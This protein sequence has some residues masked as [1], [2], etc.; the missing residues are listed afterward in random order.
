M[1]GWHDFSCHA[2]A[3]R[4]RPTGTVTFLFTDVEGS[5]RLWETAPEQMASALRRHDEI[6]RGGL[7]DAGGYVFSVAGDSFGA[8]FQDHRQAVTAARRIQAAVA[9]ERWPPAAVISV[10]IGL[11]T[12]VAEERDGN[13]FGT[14]VN[15][16]ARVMS[17]AQ[18]GQVLLSDTMRHL[19]GDGV[20]PLGAVQAKGLADA[21][22]V[23][24]LVLDGEST[25][26]VVRLDSPL[27]RS[28][29]V[30]GQLFGR[31]DDV[32]RTIALLGSRQIVTIVGPGGIG[33]T[34]L[35]RTAA[36]A[37]LGHR[38]GSYLVE[39]APVGTE[40]VV[41]RIASAVG[42][43]ERPGRTMLDSLLTYLAE[44]SVLLVVDNCEHV[45][46]TVAPLV[47]Q[48]TAT[49]PSV[50]VLA[51]S[52]EPLG[53]AD[54]QVIR[55][56]GLASDDAE[57][58][59]VELF[60]ARAARAGAALSNDRP[61]RLAVAAICDRL[62]GLPLAIE[63]AAARTRS[64]TVAEL[65][66]RLERAVQPTGK[67]RSGD[68]RHHAMSATIA[69][70]YDLLDDVER[71]V[72]ERLAVFV[73]GFDLA[74]AEYVCAD[75]SIDADDVFDVVDRLVDKSLVTTHSDG[76]VR[77][78]RLLEPMRWFAWDRLVEADV[79][80]T[81][82][83]RHLEHYA[84]RADSAFR[85]LP[86]RGDTDLLRLLDLDRANLI[87]ATEWAIARGHVDA[88]FRI[89]CAAPIGLMQLR[90]EFHD[91][92]ELLVE[93]PSAGD[94]PRF[95]EALHIPAASAFQR[96][97]AGTLARIR[98][99]SEPLRGRTDAQADL[100]EAIGLLLV[101][102][103]PDRAVEILD[104]LDTESHWVRCMSIFVGATA[105]RELD[106]HDGQRRIRE[107]AEWARSIGARAYEAMILEQLAQGE[108][109]SPQGDPELGARLA[110][111]ALELAEATGLTFV[112]H[113]AR[114]QLARAELR[115][116][117][118]GAATRRTLHTAL[119]ATIDAGVVP[120]QWFVLHTAA[121]LL[122]REGCDVEAALIE[123]CRQHDPFARLRDDTLADVFHVIVP[124]SAQREATVIAP[125]ITSTEHLSRRVLAV[126]EN[127]GLS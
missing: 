110:A 29:D 100:G 59:G 3:V 39:L 47:E 83:D 65:G 97:R 123:A 10:R 93:L 101:D 12:G 40:R 86:A 115:R 24:H 25:V 35:A 109:L 22:R 48:L 70:S 87:T 75:S 118:S 45:I 54:E 82:R 51:T 46:D 78:L 80:G 23:W 117:S 8:A 9:A 90:W 7:L 16:A 32:A 11:H 5:T 14:V 55:L 95:G 21:V 44:R 30:R 20:L 26:P 63:L 71:S 113:Q 77:R 79:L 1:V 120:N 92:A 6:L 19:V 104:R 76:G 105:Y 57:S 52:R 91:L 119:Q 37:V 62:G 112:V 61:T 18:G 103:R 56:D 106:F 68:A 72:F 84:D 85:D 114:L 42:A 74:S 53:V 121:A 64:V 43:L 58:A 49:C 15:T 2:V 60:Y 17:A 36:R 125:T 66:Q 69:W 96:S 31:A 34:S 81:I 13:Y 38:D 116:G 41:E 127:L 122:A 88:G 27:V 102:G 4:G 99:L 33:K 124:E 28:E 98:A 50:R 67:Q 108:V 94:H 73:D 89:V 107:G 111:D 126:L